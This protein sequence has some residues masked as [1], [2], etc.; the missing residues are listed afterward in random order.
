ML[1][2]DRYDIEVTALDIDKAMVEMRYNPI[3]LA[4]ARAMNK[5]PDEIDVK[6]R[7]VWVSVYDYADFIKYTYDEECSQYAE[8]FM[9]DWDDWLARYDEDE[10]AECW[11]D[12]FTCSLN[13][14]RAV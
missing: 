2:R 11:C 9:K 10:D 6:S 4:C 14:A 7:A 12:P 8:I 13:L 5:S 3:Q 1:H